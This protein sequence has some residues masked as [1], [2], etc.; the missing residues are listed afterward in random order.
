VL[1]GMLV[2]SVT[3]I[4]WHNRW[5]VFVGRQFDTVTK[6]RHVLALM[7][8]IEENLCERLRIQEIYVKKQ[9]FLRIC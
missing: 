5:F 3:S 6:H 4:E 9:I 1:A 7:L 8:Q 2:I